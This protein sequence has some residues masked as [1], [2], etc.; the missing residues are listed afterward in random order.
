MAARSANLTKKY[1][2]TKKTSRHIH[3]S[4]R[5]PNKTKKTNCEFDFVIQQDIRAGMKPYYENQIKDV[6]PT[7]LS[8]YLKVPAGE[9]R[10]QKIPANKSMDALIKAGKH[11]FAVEFKN[12]SAMAPLLLAMMN[13]G[14]KA[15]AFDKHPIP[16]V[17]VPYMGETGRRFLEQSKISWVDLSGNACIDA[18]GIYIHVT[19]KP[20]QFKEAGRPANIFAPRSSRI[21][22]VFLINPTQH[23]SQ[24]ELA[25]RTGLDEGFTSRI[26]RKFENDQLIARD[27]DGLVSVKD[28]GR[29]L[30]AWNDVYNFNKH[31][32]LKGHIAARTGDALL[33]TI[34]DTLKKR[35]VE[36]TAT[37]LGAAWL[38]D[39]FAAFRTV[40][41]YFRNPIT[42][43]ILADLGFKKDE[44]G[45]NTWLVT[46][47]DEGVFH[48]A[49]DR[50]GIRCV[51]PVQIYLDL[52]G[53]PERSAEAAASLRGKYLNWGKND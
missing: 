19:G 34:V 47:N 27:N 14:E 43:D 25:Q 3:A 1:N 32:I 18:P 40:T 35:D 10:L 52:K 45:A 51:H 21:A 22:R 33:H 7:I 50:D 6:L 29:M 31:H 16:L 8:E 9:V 48:G 30:E 4:N 53:H 37:G 36:H 20:N 23:F 42:K 28:P 15:K 26:I 46:P 39:R 49:E 13:I 12:T 38:Y 2:L 17:V 41:I 24:R 11:T 5:L 44:R